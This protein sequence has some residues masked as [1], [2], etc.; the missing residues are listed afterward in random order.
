[1]WKLVPSDEYKKKYRRFEK[2]CTHELKAVLR[3]LD[4]Y[5]EALDQGAKPKKIQGGFVHA[6]PEDVVAIDQKKGRA[7]LSQAR[8]YLFSAC[9]SRGVAPDYFGWK[10]YPTRMR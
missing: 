4:R 5:F 3:N 10:G 2:K 8:L 7:G 6:E 1:M 9:R